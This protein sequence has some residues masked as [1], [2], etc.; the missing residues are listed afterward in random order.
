MKKE[1]SQKTLLRIGHLAR[2]AGV[3]APTIKYYVREGLLPPPVKTSKNMA[4]YDESCVARIQT[5]KKFQKEQFLPLDMIKRLMDAGASHDE[6]LELGQAIFKSHKIVEG[7]TRLKAGEVEKRLG[8]PM[9]KIRIL[10]DDGLIIP[11]EKNGEKTYDETDCKIIEMMKHREALGVPFDFSV[12]TLRIYRDAVS[13]AVTGDIRHFIRHAGADRVTREII[14][15]LTKVD[16]T[17]DTF[18]VLYRYKMLRAQSG[19]AIR[20]INR[21]P[22]NLPF[23]NIFPVGSREL[24]ETPPREMFLRAFWL[25]C[26]GD[27]SALGRL[28]SGGARKK[29][30]PDIVTLSILADLFAGNVEGALAAVT[31]HIPKPSAK[32]LDNTVA[33]LVCLFN[34][35]RATGISVPLFHSKKVLAYLKRVE[36][37]EE[38]NSLVR[39]FSRYICGAAYILLP[40]IIETREKGLAIL[41]GLSDQLIRQKISF[42][43]VPVWFRR[44]LD[45]DVFPKLEVRI[46]RFL[47]YGFIQMEKDADAL[48]C[49]ERVIEIADADSRHAEWARMERIRIKR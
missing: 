44:A 39:I 1:K 27:F 34:I 12:Q 43:D 4:Y 25:L 23:L 37:A 31:T 10:E 48:P 42:G 47:A 32:T 45:F 41:S 33:A 40:E 26:R 16:E 17:L 28:A 13:R 29:V 6:E 2:L 15:S 8:Y 21:L 7:G 14:D 20:E 19:D 3:S 36:I 49:L 24:P 9:E 5:I 35:G 30:H 22:E 46:N 18:M 38:R 11:S